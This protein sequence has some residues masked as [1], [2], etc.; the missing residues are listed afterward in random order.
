MPSRW[1]TQILAGG[2][3]S[4]LYRRLVRE[5]QIA[6]DVV[7]FSMPLVAGGA[8]LAGWVTVR[9]EAR[10]GGAWRRRSWPRW[11]RSLANR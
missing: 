3:G 4:R 7:A 1:R 8:M 10:P 9:P 5:R 6:Q 2:Q 11:S